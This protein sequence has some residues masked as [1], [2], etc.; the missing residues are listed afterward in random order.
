M[1]KGESRAKTADK[2]VSTLYEQ[3]ATPPI[4]TP[5]SHVTLKFR[6]IFPAF[7]RPPPLQDKL[8]NRFR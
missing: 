4:H 5:G 8:T 7:P 2:S 3:I 1:K 6:G